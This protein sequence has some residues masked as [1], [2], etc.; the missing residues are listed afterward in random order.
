MAVKQETLQP[1]RKL[2]AVGQDGMSKSG[3]K[4]VG[5]LFTHLILA[6]GS[7]VMVGPFAWMLSSSIKTQYEI[8]K[9]P[10]TLIPESIQWINYLVVF[11]QTA[12]GR[13]VGNSMFV[14]LSVTLG[15]LLT[16]S[17][18][19]YSFSR[20]NFPGRD[21]IF[22]MYLGT[23]M[24]PGAILLIPSFVLMRTFNWIDTYYALI[25]PG[26]VSAWGT[27][28]M[29]QFMMSIP[30]ELE[31]AAYIDGATRLRIYW[32]VI[33]PVSKPVIATLAIFT[34]MGV[35]NE[36]LWPVIILRSPEKFTLPMGLAKFQSRFPNRTPWHL[37]MAASTLSVLPILFLF[38]AG[39]KYY[40]QG[41]VT[42]GL[43]G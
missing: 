29:R 32:T 38:M 42:T 22:L 25:V 15:V 9:F 37:I 27:F 35:W 26:V 3:A 6:A 24:I 23:M 5:D 30:R 11:E 31:D 40:V 39:Q 34:F 2:Q 8:Y 16:S 13:Y 43:K 10:P 18:A 12:L 33:L 21:K 14:S 1:A 20:L 4:R 28:L 19:G 41:I 17:L 7:I 36:L